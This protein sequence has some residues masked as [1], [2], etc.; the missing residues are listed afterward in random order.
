MLID[1][2]ISFFQVGL[3]SLGGGYAAL[4]LIQNQ[5]VDYDRRQHKRVEFHF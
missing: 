1:L 2:Y 4:P 3:L 5:I